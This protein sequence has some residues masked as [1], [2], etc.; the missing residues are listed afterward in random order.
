MPK[1]PRCRVRRRAI[2]SPQRKL[3]QG[4][5][6]RLHKGDAG[7][8]KSRHFFVGS[9]INRRP[10]HLLIMLQRNIF[11]CAD[12]NQ[13]KHVASSRVIGPTLGMVFA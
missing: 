5:D 10:L 1:K 6:K 3:A 8:R 11:A 2:S 9:S 12:E 13:A 7:S 4:F